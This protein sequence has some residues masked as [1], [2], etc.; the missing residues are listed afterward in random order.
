MACGNR[1]R[2]NIL[3]TGTPCTG[4][5]VLANEIAERTGLNHINV[6]DLAKQNNLFEGWDE[7]YNCHVLD[8][9]RV[10]DELEDQ[11]CEGGNVVDYHGC[12]FFP[13]RWF[14]IVFVLRTNNT[15]LYKRLEQ[16]GYSGKKLTDNVECEIM[17]TILEEARESYKTEIVHEL[18]SDTTE[19]LEN[20]LDQIVA[21]IQKWS[22]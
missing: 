7:Q 20:N 3:V 1:T 13:E 12:D 18:Q 17:Q 14:D 4:K 19:E 22:G 15:I 11:M 2:P 8:E 10:V 21:W 5:S 16:R 9:D 6:G